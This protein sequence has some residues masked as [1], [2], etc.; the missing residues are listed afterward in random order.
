MEKKYNYRIDISY[1]GTRYNGWQRQKNG[2]GIQQIIEELLEKLFKEKITLIASGRTD[3]GVHALNQV[4]NFKTVYYKTPKSIYS[5]LNAKLPRDISIKKVEEVDLSFNARFSAKGKTYLY[6]IYTKPDPFLYGRG[7]YFDKKLDIIK[8]IQAI[9]VLRKYKDLSS[10]AKEGNY[11]RKEIDLREIKLIYD[12]KILD[13]EI[14]ASHFL[15]NLVRRIVG[16]L[17]AI[18]RGSLTIE[19]F[20]EIIKSKNPSK[21]KF[22]APPEGLYLKEVYY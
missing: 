13:I 18:G 4:A 5:Y 19:E 20:E 17:V 2:I 14:T 3:A 8:M 16:H 15:R 7:W 9:E 22:L 6:R 1:I 11:L 10:L 12:G 21:G